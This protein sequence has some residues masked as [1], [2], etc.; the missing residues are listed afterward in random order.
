MISHED[1]IWQKGKRQLRKD[2]LGNQIFIYILINKEKSY[3]MD[4]VKFLRNTTATAVD[5]RK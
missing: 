2:L 4:A 5:L 3:F 1:S